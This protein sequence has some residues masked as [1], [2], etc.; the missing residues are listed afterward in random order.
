MLTNDS[1]KIVK[2][3]TDIYRLNM[4]KFKELKEL[5]NHLKSINNVHDKVVSP[6][7]NVPNL[8]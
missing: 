7:K 5:F 2:F 8:Q 4:I 6:I 1:K 3:I